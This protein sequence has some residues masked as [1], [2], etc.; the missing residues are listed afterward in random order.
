MNWMFCSGTNSH[1]EIDGITVVM[2]IESRNVCFF[3]SMISSA[4]TG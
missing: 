1:S 3:S 4:I 2:K